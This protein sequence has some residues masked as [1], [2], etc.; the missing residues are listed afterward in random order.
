MNMTKYGMVVVFA[1]A[2]FGGLALAQTPPPAPEIFWVDDDQTGQGNGSID[3][4]FATIQEGITA[5]D[6]GDFVRVKDG[7]YNENVS[8]GKAITVRSDQGPDD[9]TIVGDQTTSVVHIWCNNAVLKGFSITNG[10]GK[11]V[12]PYG[13]TYYCGG[14][15]F[16]GESES[17]VKECII[18]DCHADHFGGGIFIGYEGDTDVPPPYAEITYLVT[19]NVIY[20]CTAN[21]GGGIYAEWS[22][23]DA[24]ISWN[25]IYQCEAGSGMAIAVR[26]YYSGFTISHNDIHDNGASGDLYC[27]WLLRQESWI[28]PYTCRTIKFYN[29]IV[30]DNVGYGV[31][32][33]HAGYARIWYCTIINNEYGGIISRGGPDTWYEY[34]FGT[35]TGSIVYGNGFELYD[36]QAE[37]RSWSTFGFDYCD[38]QDETSGIMTA[39]GGTYT[40]NTNTC[41][42]NDPELSGSG[43]IQNAN[44]PCIDMGAAW[45]DVSRDIDGDS[46]VIN[47]Y[48]DIGADEYND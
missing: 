18:Y 32:A 1:L 43:R 36:C 27:V 28:Y 34:T 44:N 6:A 17:T 4:P 38:F 35:C 5:A 40:Y 8:I 31:A 24:E 39:S 46:R 15:V 2:V 9:C 23:G 47:T 20:D 26:W 10:A 11:S 29:N 3:N 14:G 45:A 12:T 48:W 25:E 41:F 21:E 16:L 22:S 33:E 42:D 13:S 7:T 37:I 30:R 19:K